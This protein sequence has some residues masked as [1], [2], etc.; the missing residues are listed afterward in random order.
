MEFNL[1]GLLTAPEVT[2]WAAAIAAIVAIIQELSWVPI[3][4]G[5][6][7]RAWA[8]SILAAGV[9]ALTIPAVATSDPSQLVAA[10]VL[11]WASL[12]GTALAANRA[13]TYASEAVASR[14]A[15][16]PDADDDDPTLNTRGDAP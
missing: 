6:R 3:P 5:S 11:S 2:S 10:A 13:G 9:V 8:V 4:A 1:P 15:T 14:L 7:A 16:D 12:A